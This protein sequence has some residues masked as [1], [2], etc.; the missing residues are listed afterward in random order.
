MKTIIGF[1]LIFLGG[2]VAALNLATMFPNSEY[3]A[4]WCN[5]FLAS[6]FAVCGCIVLHERKRSR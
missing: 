1:S 3:V 4:S 6:V 5:L 2:F